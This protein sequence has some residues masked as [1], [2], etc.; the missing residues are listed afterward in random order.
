MYNQS[1]KN[2]FQ[3]IILPEKQQFVKALYL[4]WFLSSK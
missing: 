1:F 3:L 2:C 4:F